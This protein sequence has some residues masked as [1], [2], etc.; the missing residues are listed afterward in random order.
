MDGLL[1]GRFQPFHLGHIHAI[2]FA[3]SRIDNLWIGIGSSNRSF[4]KQNPFSAAE[5][6]EMILSSLDDNHLD[7]IKIFEIPD[8][9]DHKKWAQ[10][11]KDIVPKFDIVFTNDKMTTHIYTRQGIDVLAIPFENRDFLSGTSI[12]QKIIQDQNWQDYLPQG[13]TNVLLKYGAKDRLKSVIIN[14]PK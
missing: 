6:K 10:N 7:K 1:I 13:T 9:N 4:E 8:L 14:K 11:I 3:L 2:K 12:R 5:R